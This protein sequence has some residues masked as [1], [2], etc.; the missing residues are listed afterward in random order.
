MPTALAVDL[1]EIAMAAGHHAAGSP[2]V[3]SFELWVREL[4]PE[5]GYL[6]AAGL[7]QALGHLESLRFEADEI[8]HLRTVPALRRVP[9]SFFDEFLPRLRFTGDV[10][11]VPEGTP[12]FAGEPL[13]RVTADLT[14]AQFVESVILST[15]LFQTTVA[16]KASRIVA[17]A[18]GRGVVEFGMRRAHG[19]GA[20]ALAARAAYVGGCE[21]TSNVEAG[22]RFGIPVSGTM[23]HSWV[24]SHDTEA[25]AFARYRELYGPDVV[26]VLDTY[27]TLEAARRVARGQ[28]PAAIRLDS[29]DLGALS[30]E[31]RRI[32]DAGGCGATRIL[33]SGD[34]DE[35][36]IAELVQQQAPIDGFGV[37]TAL[38][39]ATDAPALGGVYKLVEV[40]RDGRARPVGKS[41]PR[42]ETRPWRKQVWRSGTAARAEGD[43][44]TAAA[45]PVVAGAT[46]LL[47][48]VMRAGERVGS[49]P[50][51]DAA[52]QRC[53]DQ[54]AALPAGVRR[55]R[56]PA[57]Y[58]VRYS[59]LVALPTDDGLEGRAVDAG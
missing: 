13:L 15:V 6:V 3:G 54:L 45:E 49:A 34:L 44:V 31:V 30:R 24:L 27:D 2:R 38:S 57:T 21:G 36:R 9:S 50:G 55:L 39:A 16:T 53:T 17:A 29:G 14:E 37:G 8:A 20:G 19:P 47:Q 1:Y 43:I 33:A 18:A 11:A 46:P 32:L 22:A 35:H 26:L 10:W 4:P 5:R 41:S 40:E 51:L 56:R 28:P 23:A 58:P 48:P 42:K 52:R 12:I 25:E 59:P 7:E